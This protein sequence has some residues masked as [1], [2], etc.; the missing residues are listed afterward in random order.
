[1]TAFIIGQMTIEN[2]DW[3]E[4]YFAEIPDV[5]AR[6]QGS[7][8]VRGGNP[9][10]ME[11]EAALPDAAFVIRFPDRAHAEA[12]WSC[13]DFQRLAKLRRSGSSLNAILVDGTQ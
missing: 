7:F 13:D 9:T 3:M 2:R 8:S 12:F 6:H 4:A 1:M 10:R 11:G 5:V